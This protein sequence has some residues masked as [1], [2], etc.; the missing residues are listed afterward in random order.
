MVTNLTRK[1][2]ALGFLTVLALW[3]L[4]TFE[5]RLGLDLRGGARIVYAFDFEQ[6][7]ADEK[8]S[9]AEYDDRNQMLQQMADVFLRRLD[10]T[11]LADIPVYPQG[12]NQLVIELPDRSEKEVQNIK[13]IILNQGLIDFRI[14]AGNQDGVGLDGEQ[15]KLQ[16]WRDANPDGL[17]ADFNR[18]T[19]AEGGPRAEVRWFLPSTSEGSEAAANL[20]G[21]M[22]AG[23]LPLL[24]A[25]SVHPE[26]AADE[27]WEFSGADL[28]YVGPDM[29]RFNMPA[30]RFE[31]EE[32]RKNAFG[33]FTEEYE[34]RLMAI[35]LNNEVFSAPEIEGRLPGGGIIT[36]GRSGFSRSEMQE[37]IT[38]LRTGSLRILPELQSEAYVGPSLG[39]DSISA[40][41]TSAGIGGL[42]VLVFMLLYYRMNGV[43][44]T[45]A[46]LF[47]GFLLVGA[48]YFTQATLTL[49]GLAGLVLT[50]GMA[51]DANILIF[52]RVREERDRGRE[53]PQAYKNGY[54]NAF[55]TIMDANITTFLTALILASFGTGPVKGFATVLALGILTT[56]VASL[57]FSKVLM[58]FIVFGK[59]PPKEV[60][61]VRSMAGN[62][63]IRFLAKRRIAAV[64][65]TVLIVAGLFVYAGEGDDMLG[66][67]F[68]GGSMARVVLNGDVPLADVNQR[69]QGTSYQVTTVRGGK[70]EAAGLS[71]FV[72]KKKL[73]PEERRQSSDTVAAGND[74]AQQMVDD[75]VAR[76]GELMPKSADGQ[77]AEDLAI[78]EK[79]TIGGRV[80]KDIQDKAV[81]AILLALIAIVIYMT[82]RFK[83]YRYGLAAVVALFH[84]VL[85]TLG[86][87][88]LVHRL[89]IVEV[90]IDLEIIAAFLT[91]IGYSL[92]DTIVVFDRI[93]ENLPRRKEGFAE[94]IDISINQSLSRTI[95]TSVTTFLVVAV[96]FWFNRPF[97][98]VLEGFSFAML[99]GIVVGTYSSIFVASPLLVFFDR[100]ARKSKLESLESSSKREARN[101]AKAAPKA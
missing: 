78:A 19:E 21:Y 98:N 38:V 52:E 24:M 74:P 33:D 31:F 3:A 81:Q 26:L 90:E 67:D 83:E 48:L 75:L 23:A 99:I 101:Q 80:S 51:V 79:S 40:G 18:L 14:I 7:L 36:G 64:C 34:N 46:L 57:V 54:D 86:A 77:V 50:I 13:D 8:I 32:F 66:I 82:F 65:S 92:N 1:L 30:V 45:L 89:G 94:I 9:Q 58:H 93:R 59:N 20:A 5:L 61:M 55:S 35:V 25:E 11:G 37:M 68:A 76:L 49:P 88:A 41:V 70:S 39:E 10:A 97:H 73:T 100:W 69:L 96:L 85:F 95:L 63:S 27:S 62:S 56:L 12:E 4:Y 15:S 43:V 6:A 29:D 47:N 87:L 42:L 91:I 44:A 60:S 16:A 2:L 22:T 72:V 28:K 17:I 53:V 71:E 84:D